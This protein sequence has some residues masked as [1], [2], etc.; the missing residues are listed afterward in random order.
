MGSWQI[1]SFVT[2]WVTIDYTE[3]YCSGGQRGLTTIIHTC[4]RN[5]LSKV[6]S[7]SETL[8]SL[9]WMAISGLMLSAFSTPV[10]EQNGGGND[11]YNTN[12]MNRI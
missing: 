11:A 12:Y 4:L 6:D 9:T 5:A 3:A 7:Q 10:M 8:L 2:K 1:D